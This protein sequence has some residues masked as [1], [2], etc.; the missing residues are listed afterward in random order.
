[1]K[2]FKKFISLVLSCAMLMLLCV[3]ACSASGKTAL[4]SSAR[5]DEIIETYADQIAYFSEVSGTSINAITEEALSIIKDIM[6]QD[7]ALLEDEACNAMML[8]IA[9]ARTVYLLEVNEYALLA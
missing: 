1:M 3:S 6:Y 8:E 4:M 2:N 7:P 5:S 9:E